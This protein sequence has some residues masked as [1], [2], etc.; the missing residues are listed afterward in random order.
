VNR[1]V[2]AA[3]HEGGNR[4]GAGAVTL[5]QDLQAFARHA[6]PGGEAFDLPLQVGGIGQ[7]AASAADGE[8]TRVLRPFEAEVFEGLVGGLLGEGPEGGPFTADEGIDREGEVGPIAAEHLDAVVA[9]DLRAV[10]APERGSGRTPENWKTMF[11]R[12]R[13]M[14]GKT[15][16]T[17]PRK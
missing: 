9:R 5:E 10:L 2:R 13:L 4:L 11:W 15:R 16:L 14:S 12:V 7:V 3:V 6:R 17:M 1:P 8:G